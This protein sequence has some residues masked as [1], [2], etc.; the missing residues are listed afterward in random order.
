MQIPIFISLFHV[1]EKVHSNVP[2]TGQ[3][4]KLYV[5]ICGAGASHVAKCQTHPVGLKF[6]GMDMSKSLWS[7][8]AESIATVIPYVISILL[9]IASGWYQA[10][11]TMARQQNQPQAASAINSQMQFMTK[12]FPVVFGVL[13]LRF[14][15]GL[16]V[17]WVTSN[18]WRIGQQ[19]LVLNK[20]YD[21]ANAKPAPK[22]SLADDDDDEPPAIE[23][24]SRPAGAKPSVRRPGAPKG[25]GNGTRGA[26]GK[27][28][29][30]PG[31]KAPA[32]G[33]NGGPAKTTG[34]TGGNGTGKGSGNGTPA[35]LSAGA[36][37]KKR[38]R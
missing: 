13:S 19:H 5:D 28:G 20:I 16:I 7:V 2:K 1:L 25:S 23:A 8:R 26:S 29:G 11:Q 22:A 12:V 6:L 4:D 33:G 35:Q 36:R 14:A 9:I 3:F 18:L 31:A 38:K 27:G 17:Y 24:E 34:K 10:R 32:K 21:D 37:R 15:S 30:S